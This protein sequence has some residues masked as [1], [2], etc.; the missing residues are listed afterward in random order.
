MFAFL[1]LIDRLLMRVTMMV[2]VVLLT[3]AACISL[4]QVVT[5]F[6]FEEPSTWSEVAARSLIIWMVYLG[7]AVAFRRGTLMSVEYLYERSRGHARTL[8]ICLIAAV[9]LGVML[10]MGWTGYELAYRVRF[11][12]LAGAINPFTG[13]GISISWLYASVPVGAALGIV[14][15]A[16]R[17]AEQIGLIRQEGKT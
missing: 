1:R 8:L 9:S 11:Q 14:G 15:I 17:T 5:R 7:L 3:T 4:W 16:A 2:A 10:V 12:T 6:V 13:L